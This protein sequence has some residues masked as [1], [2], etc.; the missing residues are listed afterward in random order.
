MEPRILT[1]RFHGKKPKIWTWQVSKIKIYCAHCD[2]RPCL[3]LEREEDLLSICTICR[4]VNNNWDWLN[5]FQVPKCQKFCQILILQ[6]IN[7]TIDLLPPNPYVMYYI[8][9]WGLKSFSIKHQQDIIKWHSRREQT[10][11]TGKNHTS[12]VYIIIWYS[13]LQSTHFPL[14]HG[15]F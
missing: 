13:I 14:F 9:M 8:K 1:W 3:S 12:Q 2:L 5:I 10:R 7:S 11:K 6:M 15:I 4:S